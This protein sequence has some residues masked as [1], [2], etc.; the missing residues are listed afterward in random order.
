[1]H[2]FT[3]QLLERLECH[4]ARIDELDEALELMGGSRSGVGDSMRLHVRIAIDGLKSSLL[5][6][7]RV[8]SAAQ[9]RAD[10]RSAQRQSRLQELYVSGG[11]AVARLANNRGK[12][13]ECV[14]A[15]AAVLTLCSV[16]SLFRPPCHIQPP[17]RRRSPGLMML[18]PPP[19]RTRRRVR[20]AT[21]DPRGPRN[22]CSDGGGGG[23]RR[24]PTTT[25]T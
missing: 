3:A 12:W 8:L 2:E 22:R 18:S 24:I 15:R 20:S 11:A 4:A 7:G 5:H 14:R 19:A 17:L 23:A 13:R 21:T 1:M 10:R 25:C 16:V 9:R 6:L